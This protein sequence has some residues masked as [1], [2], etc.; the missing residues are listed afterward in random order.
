MILVLMVF[1]NVIVFSQ[2]S[3]IQKIKKDM[4]PYLSVLLEWGQRPEWSNKYPGCH[5]DNP[6]VSPD[7]K[8]IAIQFG[9]NVSQPGQGKGIFLFD[10]DK[11]IKSK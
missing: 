9:Y 4:P 8:T 6:V 2:E 1:Q 3:M 5:S 10:L 11:Y 7:G